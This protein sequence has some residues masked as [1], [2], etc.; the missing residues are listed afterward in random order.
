MRFGFCSQGKARQARPPGNVPYLIPWRCFFPVALTL[1]G[2]RV[3]SHLWIGSP[4]KAR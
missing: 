3:C 4:D 2:L 1:T